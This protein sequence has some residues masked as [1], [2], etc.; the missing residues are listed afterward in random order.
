MRRREF[1]RATSVAAAAAWMTSAR[2]A[3]AGNRPGG[4][5]DQVSG[6]DGEAG[7]GAEAVEDR[8]SGGGVVNGRVRQSVMG[9]CFNPMDPLT[10]A[11]HAKRIGL[12]AIEGVPAASY[13]AIRELGLEIFAHCI[14]QAAPGRRRGQHNETPRLAVVRGWRPGGRF[15]DPF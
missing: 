11:R 15:Q 5:G 3:V 4:P 2:P 6:Q 8:G 12:V 10:L 1:C 14:G 13:P 7:Q 9:W